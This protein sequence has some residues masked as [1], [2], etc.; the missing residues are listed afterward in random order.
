MSKKLPP[1]RAARCPICGQPAVHDK[2]PF[3]STRC[4]DADLNR[5]LSGAYVI[6]GADTADEPEAR[7]DPHDTEW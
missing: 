3:C 7:S 1:R 5:W 2:R 6:R 4:A